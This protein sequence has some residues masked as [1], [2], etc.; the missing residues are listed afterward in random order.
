MIAEMVEQPEIAEIIERLGI[1]EIAVV[2]IKMAATE[3]NDI[4]VNAMIDLAVDIAPAHVVAAAH[5]TNGISAIM[6]MNTRRIDEDAAVLIHVIAEI[7]DDLNH[8]LGAIRTAGAK[9]ANVRLLLA[10]AIRI[11]LVMIEDIQIQLYTVRSH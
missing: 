9:I 1:T 8:R 2:S 3:I 5:H 10:T 6:I 7:G 4:I 11:V